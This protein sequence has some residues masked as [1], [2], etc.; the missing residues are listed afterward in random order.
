[1]SVPTPARQSRESTAQL[2]IGDVAEAAGVAPGTLRM[3]ETRFG[4]PVPTRLPSGHRRYSAHDVAAVKEVLLRQETGLR[5]ESAVAAVRSRQHADEPSIFASVRASAPMLPKL[6]LRK[7]TLVALSQ[8]IEDE[9]CAR[10]QRGFAFGAFQ[11]AGFYAGAAQR[12]DDIARRSRATVVMADFDDEGVPT[13]PEGKHP[14]YVPLGS[15]TPVRDEWAV[16]CDSPVFAGVLTA[17]EP[18]GQARV[19]EG[20]RIFEAVWTLDPDPVRHAAQVCLDVAEAAH[21]D[22]DLSD[23]RTQLTTSPTSTAPTP[24]QLVEFCD[25]VI[26][27]LDRRGPN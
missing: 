19:A 10:G 15:G 9:M 3:W 20:E 11:R 23:V 27:Q 2:S 25:R 14:L 18:I 1:M 5:L 26:G 7:T 22:T 8:A 21:P 17:W 6:R 16:V 24:Q 4:F 12:W 13:H